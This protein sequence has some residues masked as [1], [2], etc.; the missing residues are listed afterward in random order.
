MSAIQVKVTDDICVQA[1]MRSRD[2]TQNRSDI[3]KEI[4][5]IMDSSL[6]RRDLTMGAGYQRDTTSQV[7]ALSD[8]PHFVSHAERHALSSAVDAELSADI[9]MQ[10]DLMQAAGSMTKDLK[11]SIVEI[12]AKADTYTP[13]QK[14]K[15]VA[16]VFNTYQLQQANT[17]RIALPTAQIEQLANN[18]LE[19][20]TELAA[21]AVLPPSLKTMSLDV[22]KSTA[23]VFRLPALDEA[24]AKFEKD[25]S[26]AEILKQSVEALTVTLL[27]LLEQEDLD[28]ETRLD[29][30]DALEQL[31][32][33]EDGEPIPREILKSLD[34]IAAQ[35]A[36]KSGHPILLSMAAT[37]NQNIEVVREANI[38]VKA[39]KFNLTIDQVRAI[40]AT[41]D[42]LENLGKELPNDDVTLK[43]MIAE[44][45][46]SL[47]RDPVSIKAMANLEAVT[48]T[49]Q[50]PKFKI[51][52]RTSPVIAGL[53]SPIVESTRFVQKFLTE[54][55][56]KQ[57][58]I[59][60][61][62]VKQFTSV[63]N[64]IQNSITKIP[65]AKT[66]IIATAKQ[67]LKAITTNPVS[68]ATTGLISYVANTLSSQNINPKIQSAFESVQ[69][70]QIKLLE[71]VH[72]VPARFIEKSVNMVTSL[73]SLR[74]AVTP[75]TTDKKQNP[76]L[77][78]IDKVVEAISKSP[79]SIST[80]VKVTEF[81]HDK[82]VEQL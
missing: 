78:K 2:T 57:F 5:K 10:L 51:L 62:A 7:L 75:S 27:A 20:M 1:L 19:T 63:Y 9:Q 55:V 81:L 21:D 65:E 4:A 33:I 43:S 58:N 53:A 37:L 48:K 29:I 42:R 46:L 26:P 39:E 25:T 71:A 16:V 80:L 24:I 69:R 72:K 41:M 36:E 44:A 52:E 59:P 6:Q 76:I 66:E 40:E 68:I 74:D 18:T 70:T 23:E 60:R 45:I 34:G 31:N 61:D 11:D 64:S 3:A 50:D 38:P 28:K 49:L 13:A 82:G 79:V 67:A 56:A 22:V 14:A 30:E 73:I 32:A 35:I 77:Q 47:D 54:G 12:S 8:H 15:F 17:G